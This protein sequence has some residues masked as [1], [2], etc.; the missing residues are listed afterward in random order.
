MHNP[1][2]KDRR[3]S[4]KPAQRLGGA[5]TCQEP[6]SLNDFECATSTQALSVLAVLK[7]STAVGILWRSP[8]N[9]LYSPKAVVRFN[10]VPIRPIHARLAYWLWEDPRA[11]R[12][13]FTRVQCQTVI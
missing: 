6:Q 7:V 2:E 12:D 9:N 13:H 1:G 4:K 5:K 11:K 3:G 8:L 10:P